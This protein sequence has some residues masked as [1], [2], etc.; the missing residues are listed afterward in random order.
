MDERPERPAPARPDDRA[1]ELPAHP[2][3]GQSAPAGAAVPPPTV[4]NHTPSSPARTGPSVDVGH[5]VQVT[6]SVV[7]DREV[8]VRLADGR[9]GVVP[10]GELDDAVKVG[11]V[12]EAA[13]LAREDP[14]QRAVLSVSWARKQR[15]WERVTD[16][17][18]AGT[19]LHGK[20]LRLTKGGAVVDLGL[21]A[22]MPASLAGESPGVD[23]A[24]LV[25]TELDVAVVEV[26][27]EDERV[28]VSARAHLR[29][30]RR[31][32]EKELLRSLEP[33]AEV[34][35]RIVSTADYGAVVDLGGVR[36]LVHRSELTW[37]R[38]ESVEAVVSVGDEVDVV[39]LEVHKGK[40]KISLSLRATQPDP[41]AAVQVGS[42]VSATVVRVVDY[43]VFVRL[44]DGGAEGLVHVSELSDV[45]GYRPDQ[46]VV[47]GEQLMVKVLDLDRKRRRLGLSVRRVLV[48]D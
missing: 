32:A 10:A 2:V 46:L 41:F 26:D 23:L 33:G 5:L 22:F 42:V 38:L 15:A 31:H 14:L 34:H 17:H 28:I 27:R 4:P 18:A 43:G 30:Q 29:R 35:G 19:S 12:V 13:Q 24:A 44:D 11:D 21:R 37:G 1:G 9:T 3:I 39:V 47:P 6:V 20:V 48:D 25:G 7:G 45:P 36:G 40:P 8:E 16:A